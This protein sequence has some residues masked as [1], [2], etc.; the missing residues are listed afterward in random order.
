MSLLTGISQHILKDSGWFI[1]RNIDSA[2]WLELLKKA[3][4]PIFDAVVSILQQF[5]GLQVKTLP[6]QDHPFYIEQKQKA[7]LLSRTDTILEFFPEKS[8]ALEAYQALRWQSIR[9]LQQTQRQIAPIG[10]FRHTY[11]RAY[12]LFVLSDG[13]IYGGGEYSLNTNASVPGLF[14]LGCDIEDAINRTIGDFLLLW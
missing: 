7:I 8:S 12:S 13:A 9:Y 2:T 6:F 14:Y 11:P 10:I 3:G 1:E 5:G 4:Y